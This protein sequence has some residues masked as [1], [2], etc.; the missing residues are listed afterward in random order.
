MQQDSVHLRHP[1]GCHFPWGAGGPHLDPA[2]Q[3]FLGVPVILESSDGQQIH[4]KLLGA[5]V[6]GLPEEPTVRQGWRP[7]PET[8]LL[9]VP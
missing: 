4:H 7:Q 9:P 1:E 5:Y 3:A 8:H 6:Q 2:V